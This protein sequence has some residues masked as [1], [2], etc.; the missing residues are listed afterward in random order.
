MSQICEQCRDEGFYYLPLSAFENNR[1]FC[2]CEIGRKRK[3]RI[4]RARAWASA[5]RVLLGAVFVS[6]FVLG[7]LYLLFQG[8]F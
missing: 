3:K 6:I 4:M 5:G 7:F 2:K 1:Y 8:E